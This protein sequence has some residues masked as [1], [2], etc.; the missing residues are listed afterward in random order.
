MNKQIP[1]NAIKG[2]TQLKQFDPFRDRKSSTQ[3][4]LEVKLGLKSKSEFPTQRRSS[5]DINKFKNVKQG[6][7][8]L[9]L[10]T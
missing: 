10:K 6:N 5:K 3:E 1:L 7:F 8:L 9:D 2:I 4:A